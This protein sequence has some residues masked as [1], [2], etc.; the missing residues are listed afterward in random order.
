MLIS[1]FLVLVTGLVVNLSHI[2]QIIGINPAY[3]LLFLKNKISIYECLFLLII[4]SFF[5]FQSFS[6]GF[7]IIDYLQIIID[8]SLGFMIFNMIRSTKNEIIERSLNKFSNLFIFLAVLSIIDYYY[9][10]KIINGFFTFITAW[11]N[12]GEMTILPR[13]SLTFG[14]PNWAAFTTFFFLVISYLINSSNHLKIKLLLLVF[15]FQ[16]KSA[17]FISLFFI[18]FNSKNGIAK[19]FLFSVSSI[20]I[21]FTFSNSIGIEDTASFFNR[22]IMYEKII[23]MVELYPMCLL[24]SYE[25]R[26]ISNFSEDTLPSFLT[27]L[28]GIGWINFSLIFIYTFFKSFNNKLTF[29]VTICLLGFSIVYSFLTVSIVSAIGITLL[30][31]GINKNIDKIDVK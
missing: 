15:F 10:G 5:I 13:L 4:F 3:A 6:G 11:P 25:I 18:I 9:L 28:Y 1:K 7:I 16:S 14:N 31:F 8:L 29:S 2:Q 21:Y 24:S 26:S 22:F 30:L 12:E 17:I 20:I 23:S 19:S 27:L